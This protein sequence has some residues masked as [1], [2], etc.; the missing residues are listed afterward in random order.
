M[1]LMT[2]RDLFN[3][4]HIRWGETRDEAHLTLDIR[5]DETRDDTHL[6]LDIRCDETRDET[7]LTS[8]A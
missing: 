7:H 1:P 8:E 6:T 4:S 3:S 5:C 2:N